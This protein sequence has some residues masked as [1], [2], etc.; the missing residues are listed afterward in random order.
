MFVSAAV[1]AAVL[2][3]DFV[4]GTASATPSAVDARTG[5]GAEDGLGRPFAALEARHG[6]R[7]GVFAFDSGTGA[8]LEHRA[9]ER[10]PMCSTFKAVL[11][12]AVLEN[13]DAGRERLDRDVTYAARDLLDY[14]PVTRANF[15]HGSMTV[16]ALCAAAIE[17][18]D[19]TAANLLLRAV[20]GP[21]RVTAFV[22][23][24]GDR[25]TR[26][27]RIEPELNAA[28]AGDPRDT[29]TPAAMALTLHVLTTGSALSPTSRKELVRWLRACRTGFDCLRAGLPRGWTAG[30]KT[31]SGAHG[32]RNDI[33]I[34][35]PPGSRP[36][37]FVAAYYT[38]S[39]A[40]PDERAAVLASV[41]RIVSSTFA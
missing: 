25:K 7:L 15:A 16:R 39:S 21:A 26:L 8:R 20:G 32:T 36:P 22:R 1:A 5:I 31:G 34:L 23:S 33:A 40:T 12:G 2:R 3:P 29:T 35:E 4:A 41:G 38:G 9:H 28:T 27:D 19:N 18:S 30:D 11:V 10:F 17:E 24:L 14:A 6:G 13:A 37:V